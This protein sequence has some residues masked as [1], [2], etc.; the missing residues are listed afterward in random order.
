MIWNKEK[1]SQI[2]CPQMI[3][4]RLWLILT[5][6]HRAQIRGVCRTRRLSCCCDSETAEWHVRAGSPEDL[7][8]VACCWNIWMA[9]LRICLSPPPPPSSLPGGGWAAGLIVIF[10]GKVWR[11]LDLTLKNR[12]LETGFRAAGEYSPN[13]THGRTDWRARIKQEMTSDSPLSS[14]RRSTREPWENIL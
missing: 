11:E 13:R 7:T 9:I 8:V 2:L 3:T 10:R 4:M 6:V 14:D 5:V 12:V 1:P